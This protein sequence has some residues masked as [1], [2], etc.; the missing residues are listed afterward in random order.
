MLKIGKELIRDMEIKYPGISKT[1]RFYDKA[2]LPAC[3]YC[4]SHDTA[5]VGCGIIGRTVHLA[6][7]TTKFRLV[8]NNPPGKYF[9][10][11]CNDFFND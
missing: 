4:H 11:A 7:A 9:C 3:P 5:K 1:I 8:A 6:L 2:K 10:N